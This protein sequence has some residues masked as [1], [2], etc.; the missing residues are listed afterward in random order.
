MQGPLWQLS[1]RTITP[2]APLFGLVF[3]WG[4]LPILPMMF[5]LLTWIFILLLFLLSE[6]FEQLGVHDLIRF[7]AVRPN[8]AP[9][10]PLE[11]IFD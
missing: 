5:N 1:S 9:S 6:R 2:T 7:L 10:P 11:E 3:L 8:K 4:F